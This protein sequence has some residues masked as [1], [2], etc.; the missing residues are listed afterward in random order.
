MAGIWTLLIPIF[1]SPILSHVY[2]HT[3]GK[4]VEVTQL[5]QILR[6]GASESSFLDNA[7]IAVK[8]ETESFCLPSHDFKINATIIFETTISGS[9]GFNYSF[10][11]QNPTIIFTANSCKSNYYRQMTWSACQNLILIFN[12][13]QYLKSWRSCEWQAVPI[14]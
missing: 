11:Y 1:I 5:V 13:R 14:K 6:C 7:R 10:A 12:K 8:F 3:E 2:K 9:R 4:K